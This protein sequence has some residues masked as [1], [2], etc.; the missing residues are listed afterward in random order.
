[1]TRSVLFLDFDNTITR[2]DLLDAI[3]ERF[4]KDDT[5]RA[6]EAAWQNG[7][8]STVECLQR[9]MANV[10]PLRTEILEFAAA[11]EIDPYFKPLVRCAVA[12]GIELVVLS[13]NFTVLIDAV[14]ARHAL[15]R[16]PVLAND[17]TF[18]PERIEVDFPHRDPAC[19]RCAHCKGRDIRAVH[20]RT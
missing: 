10:K 7:A 6:W 2:G 14:F 15:P 20:G 5:W 19:P 12:A 1:M 4:S 18:L 11:T 17:L 16:L 3:L 8:I 9:Q 13:D